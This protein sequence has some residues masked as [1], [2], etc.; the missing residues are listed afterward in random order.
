MQSS[1]LVAAT[2]A[3]TLPL[4]VSVGHPGNVAV[5]LSSSGA[6]ST[7]AAPALVVGHHTRSISL[8]DRSRSSSGNAVGVLTRHNTLG[9]AP[10][11]TK[12]ERNRA[13]IGLSTL[14]TGDQEF[15]I[16]T[17][18]SSAATPGPWLSDVAVSSEERLSLS[19]T[20]N[21]NGNG[22]DGNG[23]T[24]G[25]LTSS[26]G[27]SPLGESGSATHGSFMAI[28]GDRNDDLSKRKGSGG[29]PILISKNSL[30]DA[31]GDSHS[32]GS[33]REEWESS[34]MDER[35]RAAMDLRSSKN[36]VRFSL[37]SFSKPSFFPA[38]YS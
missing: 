32:N 24:N 25:V 16:P 34:L 15:Y 19:T 35:D 12:I 23:I 11:L 8:S 14:L 30:L 38:H 1:V 22:Y 28:K 13:R 31:G 17:S 21:G 6:V 37:S 10:K 9:A 20:T 2:S 33:E 29:R 7:N 36:D 5:E 26:P 3:H 27:Y 4:E 18:P